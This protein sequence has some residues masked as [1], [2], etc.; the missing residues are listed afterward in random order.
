[1]TCPFNCSRL[2]SRYVV[3]GRAPQLPEWSY[4]PDRFLIQMMRLVCG[5]FRLANEFSINDDVNIVAELVA[6]AIASNLET[7]CMWNCG[8]KRWAFDDLIDVGFIFGGEQDDVK[9]HGRQW[10]ND[11]RRPD[12]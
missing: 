12:T 8:E 11:A 9:N 7:V 6:L 2:A 5:E 1:M 3:V 10:W 4:S